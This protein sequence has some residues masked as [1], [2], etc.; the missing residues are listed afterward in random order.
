MKDKSYVVD[1]IIP[2]YRPDE[3]FRKLVSMLK[4]QTYPIHKI[5]IMNTERDL[6]DTADLESDAG[7][8]IH[9]ITK[10]EFDHGGTRNQ[11]AGY[12]TADLMVFITQDAV[13]AD[14]YLIE[15]LTE[16]FEDPRVAVS[17]ARQLPQADC[18][19]IE[20][21]TRSFN[22]PDQDM[23]KGLGDLERLG[24]K[25]YFCSNACAAYRRDVYTEL[26]GFSHNTI[27]NEDMLF[28]AGAVKKGYFIRY[29]SKA[30]VVHSHNYSNMEQFRRNFDLA[31]SQRDH[32]EIFDGIK[33]EKEGLRLVKKTAGYLIKQKKYY[34]IP[35][36]IIKSGFKFLG[37]RFGKSYD[38]L[39]RP[40][41]LFCTMN[42]SYWGKING[43]K[44]K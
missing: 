3:K 14:I 34:L 22:Y 33:S 43:K 26:G 32:P 1:V 37:Y 9:H 4:K 29:A 39:P 12:S 18:G 15:R 6:L 20:A 31:V 30:L 28:A 42:K 8:E 24:I 40:V 5:I 16:S 17:Y 11:G 38:R 2:V 21:Y 35:D 27:F 19:M 25:T 10:A 23:V 7:I 36:L 13:P 44:A 41:I